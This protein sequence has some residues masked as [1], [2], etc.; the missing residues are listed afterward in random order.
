MSEVYEHTSGNQVN[1]QIKLCVHPTIISKGTKT[2][3]KRS[4]RVV[5]WLQ[6]KGHFWDNWIQMAKH[7]R[8][9]LLF[10]FKRHI[11]KN[12]INS[13]QTF[14]VQSWHTLILTTYSIFGFFFL[15]L[16]LFLL[17]FSLSCTHFFF[18][19]AFTNNVVLIKNF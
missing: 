6:K 19:F 17:F 14:G 10:T 12:P 7:K 9:F 2:W 1:I 18:L 8:T 4:L 13:K 15:F 3:I 5:T 16:F 11:Y